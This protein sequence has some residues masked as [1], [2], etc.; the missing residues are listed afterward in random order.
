M[1]HPVIFTLFKIVIQLQWFLWS[2]G[3]DGGDIYLSDNKRHP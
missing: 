1:R 3:H 2:Y